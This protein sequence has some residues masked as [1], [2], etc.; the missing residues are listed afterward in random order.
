MHQVI[1]GGVRLIAALGRTAG[2]RVGLR[3]SRGISTHTAGQA[4]VRGCH[5]ALPKA[6]QVM[7][8]EE[9]WVADQAMEL[10]VRIAGDIMKQGV[11]VYVSEEEIDGAAH[12]GAI[13]LGEAIVN[14]IES[15]AMSIGYDFCF[16][17]INRDGHLVVQADVIKQVIL[18]GVGEVLDD[19]IT[20]T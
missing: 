5:R 14:G 1:I 20:T 2:G 3:F 8:K 19:H 6:Y 9:K 13:S 15:R 10:A 7:T 12:R 11:E 4:A 16:G 17:K 18:A